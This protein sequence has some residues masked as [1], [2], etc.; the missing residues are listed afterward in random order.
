L[1]IAEG[2]SI[3]VAQDGSIGVAEINIHGSLSP[4]DGKVVLSQQEAPATDSAQSYEF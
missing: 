3:P 4:A 1:V 2:G